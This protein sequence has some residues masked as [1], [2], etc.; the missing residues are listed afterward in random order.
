MPL[1]TT[2]VERA[3]KLTRILPGK[4]NEIKVLLDEHQTS[5]YTSRIADVTQARQAALSLRKE[6]IVERMRYLLFG[7]PIR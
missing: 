3:A 6:V 5:L 4:A 2:P 7:K 1:H